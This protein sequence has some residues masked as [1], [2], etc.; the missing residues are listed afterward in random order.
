MNRSLFLSL[1]LLLCTQSALA[2]KITSFNAA[3]NLGISELFYEENTFYVIQDNELHTVQNYCVDKP[4]QQIEEYKLLEFLKDNYLAIT[5]N[6]SG[7]F[8]I[9]AKVRG[10]GGGPIAASIGYWATKALAYGGLAAGATVATVATGGAVGAVGA[11]AMGS[12]GATGTIAGAA[13]VAGAGAATVGGAV[14][15]AG[16]TAA[17]AAGVVGEAIVG[18]GAAATAASVGTS[19]VGAV[20]A[21]GVVAGIESGATAVGTFLLCCPF[22]P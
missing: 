9:R 16:A 3:Q 17:V 10:L 1:L 19:A 6:D 22:L 2:F 21:A 11:V 8:S 18:Y 14:A 15:G 13:A 12:V 5:Q 7:D 20:G 4:L